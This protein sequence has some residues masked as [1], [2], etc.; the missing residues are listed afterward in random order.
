MENVK[1]ILSAKKEWTLQRTRIFDEIISG[2]KNPNNILSEEATNEEDDYGLL[3]LSNA[4]KSDLLSEVIYDPRDFI[5]RCEDYG[6]PQNRHRII[7]LGARKDI[8]L[9]PYILEKKSNKTT[10]RDVLEKMPKLRSAVSKTS[11]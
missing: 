11:S 4:P 9:K 3:S 2:L 10:V 1:G 6:V 5:I 8:N 7:I